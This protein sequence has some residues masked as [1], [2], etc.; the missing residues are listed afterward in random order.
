MIILRLLKW[1]FKLVTGRV[2]PGLSG[3]SAS[4]M[5]AGLLG[6]NGAQLP[7]LLKKLT[8]GG[9]GDL[10]QSWVSK[11]KNMPLSAAQ[12][13]S[14]LGSETLSGLAG[15]MG[16]SES[17]AASKV[18]GALPQLIDQ[19]TP[20]GEVPDQQTLSAALTKLLKR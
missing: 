14:A 13:Q 19:L 5:V 12:V 3:K 10:V 16:V 4:S 2:L 6:Q 17:K 8:T 18:A 15:Q 1:V 9:L 20:D 7:E 11:G